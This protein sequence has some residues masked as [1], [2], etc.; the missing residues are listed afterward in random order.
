MKGK[1]REG[2]DR[3]GGK[4]GER[5]EGKKGKG[6]KGKGRGKGEWDAGP[7]GRQVPGAPHWQKTGLRQTC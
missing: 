2:G 5:G 1:V 3:K 7:T 4:V 6:M